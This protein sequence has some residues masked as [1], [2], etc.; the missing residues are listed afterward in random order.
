M[1]RTPDR[2]PRPFLTYEDVFRPH[3]EA[4]I[5]LADDGYLKR[6][7]AFIE[8]LLTSNDPYA[9]NVI[10]VGILE[11]LK[12]NCDHAPVRAFLGPKSLEE[13]DSLTY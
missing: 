8:K 9:V 13:F 1:E 11:G 10:Y 12:A 3:L 4:A 2:S 7:G 6:A 5:E